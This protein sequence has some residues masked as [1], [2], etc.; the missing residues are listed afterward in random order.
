MLRR[1]NRRIQEGDVVMLCE[2]FDKFHL[3]V[4]K[5]TEF[6]HHR[7]GKFAHSGIIG[8]KFGTRVRGSAGGWLWVLPLAPDRW[9]NAVSHRT[10][11]MYT[12]DIS[13]VI[14]NLNLA[15]GFVVAEAGQPNVAFE[16]DCDLRQNSFEF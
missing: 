11:I 8:K 6:F 9:I 12:M 2:R 5:N 14:M 7:F 1:A 13:F 15:P 3:V 16:C 4:T 10:Q